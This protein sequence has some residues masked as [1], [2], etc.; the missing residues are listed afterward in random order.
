MLAGLPNPGFRLPPQ[1]RPPMPNIP[2][3]RPA[4]QNPNKFRLSA[5]PK[6]TVFVGNISEEVETELLQQ[7][8]EVC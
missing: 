6:T 2:P 7:I 1:L 4:M 3:P 5:P 8:C